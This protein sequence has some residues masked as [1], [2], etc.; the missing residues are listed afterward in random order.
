MV[1]ESPPR[2]GPRQGPQR[3]GRPEHLGDPSAPARAGAG[4]G[5][6]DGL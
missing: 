5:S 1:L 6:M 3:P 2:R 4:V